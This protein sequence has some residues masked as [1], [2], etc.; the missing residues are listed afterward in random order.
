MQN[1]YSVAIKSNLFNRTALY[2]KSSIPKSV[3]NNG[4]EVKVQVGT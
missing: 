2:W 3:Q 4:N 1:Y